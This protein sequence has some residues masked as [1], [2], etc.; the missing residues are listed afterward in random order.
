M[1]REQTIMQSSGR[2]YLGRVIV[3]YNLY[4]S[5]TVKCGD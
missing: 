3:V 4:W 2:T 1:W 5:W